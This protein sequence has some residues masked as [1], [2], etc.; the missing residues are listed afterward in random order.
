MEYFP[1]VVGKFQVL[2][3]RGQSKNLS[4]YF[5]TVV[6][7]IFCLRPLHKMQCLLATPCRGVHGWVV[8][9][10]VEE[11]F[12]INTFFEVKSPLVSHLSIHS[13]LTVNRPGPNSPL[14]TQ[15]SYAAARGNRWDTN[16]TSDKA[17][18]VSPFA[19][20]E[21]EGGEASTKAQLSYISMP[22]Y[23]CVSLLWVRGLNR[24]QGALKCCST[25]TGCLR[26]V[27]ECLC[28]L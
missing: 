25:T 12:S 16:N 10:S 17:P 21:E 22:R 5:G 15:D 13:L 6:R 7:T 28:F 9:S 2:T 23:F 11:W 24:K 1:P 3:Q 19:F 18:H 14:P 4:V 20:I 27:M 26:K 8:S